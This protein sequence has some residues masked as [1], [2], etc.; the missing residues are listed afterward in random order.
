MVYAQ[1]W[2]EM[3]LQL[4]ERDELP[5]D[6]WHKINKTRCISPAIYDP[7]ATR[8]DNNVL[9]W[10]AWMAIDID[11]DGPTTPISI[12]Q[13]EE[14]MQVHDLNYLIYATPKA[15]PEKPRFR[16][17]FPISRELSVKEIKPAW[18]AMV[19]FFSMLGPDP[20]CKDLSR[21]YIG[22][23][24]WKRGLSRNAE[25]N[26]TPLYNVFEFNIDGKPL[27]ID[28]V[29]AAY[30]PPPAP[31]VTPKTVKPVTLLR[32]D[33]S[34]PAKPKVSL[35]RK[36]LPLGHHLGNSP[37]VHSKFID[38]YT[39]LGK[40]EH[41]VGMFRFMVRVIGRADLRGFEITPNDLAEY[42]HQL[43]Y[44]SPIKTSSERWSRI[45]YEIERA[46]RFAAVNESDII[47]E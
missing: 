30:V 33:V 18:A 8:R 22:P 10:A 37:V 47:E 34:T 17:L 32:M 9:G 39:Q 25:A 45:H 4:S 36:P 40:G 44:V 46:F 27:D 41:H 35:P 3:L 29:M 24:L 5:A 23:A 2:G 6:R 12:G 26:A 21:L 7:G 31:E 1:E 15:T 42:C 11:N 13:A 28:A 38:E 20:L 43:D 19:D 14:V 16:I